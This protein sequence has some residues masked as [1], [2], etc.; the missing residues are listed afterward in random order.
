[1]IIAKR[2]DN[3][4]RVNKIIETEFSNLNLK[5]NKKMKVH[6][7]PE[8]KHTRSPKKKKLKEL[9]SWINIYTYLGLKLQ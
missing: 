9:N 8:K 4:N 1:V 7:N 6:E 2:R 5:L 3:F